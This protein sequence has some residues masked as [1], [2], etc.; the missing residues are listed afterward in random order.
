MEID[1]DENVFVVSIIGAQSSAKSTLL[2][3]VFGCGFAT[4]AGRCTKGL[5]FTIIKRPD[6]K[7]IVVIDT[8]GLLSI[9]ARDHAFDN[10][11]TTMTFAISNLVIINNKGEITSTFQNLLGVCVYALKCLK[12][13]GK[14][15]PKDQAA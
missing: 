2:N 14:E 10:Q 9:V 11:I 5:Y 3:Y 4:S 1:Y 6:N 8:E 7:R 15:K 13:T 12:L